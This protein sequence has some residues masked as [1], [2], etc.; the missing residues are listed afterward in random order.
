MKLF[1][2]LLY[3]FICLTVTIKADSNDD[4]T[5][6]LKE[7][8]KL[9]FIRHA[10]AP[11]SGDPNNFDISDCSTQRNLNEKGI[12]EAKNIG[13]FFK[14][15]NIKID[16]VLSSEWCRCKDTASYAFNFFESKSFLNSFYSQKFMQNKNEQ[17]KNLKKYIKQ[18]NSEKNLVMVTHFVVISEVLNSGASPAEIIITDKKFKVLERIKLKN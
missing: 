18:W 10:Y 14:R 3:I 5:N 16:K 9:I 17:I 15:N 6:V 8:G 4:L 7:G 11:G 13:V 12:K 1:K 2:T